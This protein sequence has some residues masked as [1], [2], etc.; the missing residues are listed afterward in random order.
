MRQPGAAG[1]PEIVR[2]PGKHFLQEDQ[3][4]AL[5]DA[6]AGLIRSSQPPPV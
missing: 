2:L 3:A 4:P 1:V 5:A 6:I